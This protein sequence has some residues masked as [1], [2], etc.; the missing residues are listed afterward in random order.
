M[1]TPEHI[2]AIGDEIAIRW[3][4]GVEDYLPMERLRAWSPSAENVGERDLLGKQYGGTHQKE[5]PGVIV[6]GWNVIGGYA[7]QFQFSDGHNTGLYGF[8]YLRKLGEL[9]RA[10]SGD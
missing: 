3:S 1:T 5:F 10:Q 7:V 9:Q 8:D 4:D 6:Q 2:A